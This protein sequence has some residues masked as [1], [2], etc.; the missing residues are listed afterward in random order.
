MSPDGQS[1]VIRDMIEARASE[2]PDQTAVIFVDGEE[3][4]FA[5]LR[6]R[7][8]ERAAGLEALGVRQD[9]FVLSW[10]PNGPHAAL[11]FLALNYLGAVYVPINIS[12]RGGVLEHVVRNSGATLMIAHGALVERLADIHRSG[13]ARVVVVGDERP[14]IP[15]LELVGQDS[16]AAVADN[17]GPPA[18]PLGPWDTHMVIYTSGTTGPSKGVLASYRHSFTAAR[19]FRNVV[20]GDRNFTALPLYHVGGV[21]AFLWAL[22]HSGAVVMAESFKTDRFW[23]IMRRYEVTT[24]GLLGTMVRFLLAQPPSPM[25]RRHSLTSVVIAP[26]D[27]AAPAFAERFGVDVYTE[28]NMTELSVPLFAGPNPTAAGACGKPRAGVEVRLVDE[29]DMDVPAGTPGELILR[30]DEPW[31]MSHGYLNDPAATAQAWRNGWFHTG[32]LFRCDEEGNY[33]FLDRTKDALRRRGENISSFEVESAIML[34]PAVREAAV[35]AAPGEGGEDEVLAV[36]ATKEGAGI[37][38]AELLDF[39]KPRLAHFMLPRYVRL[40]ADL[41]K[42]PTH[43]VEKHRLRAAGVT[44]DTWDREA[45]GFKVRREQLERR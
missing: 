2:R 15:G 22:M 5:E 35:V 31:T 43:K 33:V 6:R 1:C 45:A 7:V 20:A 18:R 42:T 8:R 10:Q 19:E 41:P 14:A 11:T 4:T 9:D 40:M 13:L 37:D 26:F 23:E 38:P 25:D 39:L 24:T 3:W 17:L 28:F 32:D 44:P 21:Y 36:L 12:Y 29:H 16:L 27:E 34:H 30:A